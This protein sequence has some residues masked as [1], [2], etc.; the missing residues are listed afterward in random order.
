MIADQCCSARGSA[1]S[2]ARTISQ[3]TAA[4]VL[5]VS[6][7]TYRIESGERPLTGDGW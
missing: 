7:P 3:A 1:N 2:V 4:A 5:E 6:Q